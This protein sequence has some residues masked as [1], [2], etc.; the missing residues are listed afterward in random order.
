MSQFVVKGVVTPSRRL[1]GLGRWL[2][3]GGVFAVAL[4][5]MPLPQAAAISRGAVIAAIDARLA[6]LGI[7]SGGVYT[8][9]GG[10]ETLAETLALGNT[11]TAGTTIN[12]SD[13]STQTP[14]RTTAGGARLLMADGGASGSMFFQ[15]GTSNLSYLGIGN[16]GWVTIHRAAALGAPNLRFYDGSAVRAGLTAP[17]IGE[18]QIHGGEILSGVAG[19]L[20]TQNIAP[21]DS[22]TALNFRGPDGATVASVNTSLVLGTTTSPASIAA[23]WS[24]NG[25]GIHAGAYPT[26]YIRDE[27]TSGTAGGTATTGSWETRTLNTVEGRAYSAGLVSLSSNQ[28]TLQPG[29]WEIRWTAPAHKVDAHQSRLRNMTLGTTTRLGSSQR[30]SSSD[31]SDNVSFGE[32]TVSISAATTFEIQHAVGSTAATDGYGR[33]ASNG[34]EVYTQV[35]VTRLGA[36]DGL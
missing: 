35:K 33:P 30:C 13:A 36:P 25:G 21:Y 18:L 2:A 31:N 3:F 14:L 26:A 10:G 22:S 29:V 20:R 5:I 27:K 19:V 16:D 34:T 15:V 9:P 32:W 12:V 24:G 7:T 17:A 8:P 11:M 28:F 6:Q 1:R 4:A 23:A